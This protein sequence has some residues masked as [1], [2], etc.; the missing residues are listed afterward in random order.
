MRPSFVN[1]VDCVILVPTELRREI[2]EEIRPAAK[3][4]AD[5]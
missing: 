2:A 4:Y 3:N 5:K 1:G